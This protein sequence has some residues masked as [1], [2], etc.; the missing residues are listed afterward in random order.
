MQTSLPPERLLAVIHFQTEIAKTGLDLG[1][2]VAR[3]A[4]LARELCGATGAVV[5]M[6]DGEDMVAR[7]ATG[8]AAPMLGL[9][10]VRR[11]S[12]SGV[13]LEEGR[14]LVCADSETDPR[15]DR[16]LCR[17]VGLRSMAVAPLR[18][19]G[20]VVGALK[21]LDA[22]LDA[23]SPA[24]VEALELITE[25]IAAAMAHATQ[26]LDT[27]EE[28]RTLYQRATRDPLTGLANRA[29]LYDHLQLA[30]ARAERERLMLGVALVDMDGL[31]DINDHLGHA[32]GDEAIRTLAR[33]LE[34]AT[35][36]A[37]TVARLG[38]DEF[39]VLLA[40]V[41]DPQAAGE[42]AERLALRLKGPFQWQGRQ[43]PMSA[44]V[45]VAV[46]P[47]DGTDLETLVGHADREMYAMKE[48]SRGGP[49]RH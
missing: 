28:A 23:F 11:G 42:F 20:K 13:C 2:V 41:A 44:S 45:G 4:D 12:L 30:L 21:V 26:F 10:F 3:T 49:A 36:Q 33:R 46:Y 40:S 22:R 25:V 14:T 9:R 17:L 34:W 16:A 27:R 18:H 29:L 31:K 32:A 24:D 5:E 47:G 7:A 8:I 39:A 1:E 43:V 19:G 37:D 15:V 35:R 6:A 38:G 48:R